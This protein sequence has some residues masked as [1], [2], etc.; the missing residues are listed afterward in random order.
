MQSEEEEEEEEEVDKE[1]EEGEEGEGEEEHKGEMEGV[2]VTKS[3]GTR[4]PKISAKEMG[5]STL[6]IRNLFIY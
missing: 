6:L 4:F 3:I 5:V 2:E 1:E